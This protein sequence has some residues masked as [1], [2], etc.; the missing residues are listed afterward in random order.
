MFFNA[1]KT[2]ALHFN[3]A[4]PTLFITQIISGGGGTVEL[5]QPD[6]ISP[7]LLNIWALSLTASAFGFHLS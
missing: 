1:F 5:P 4:M 3:V 6:L 7:T 2:A